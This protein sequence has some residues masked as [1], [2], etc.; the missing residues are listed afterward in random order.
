M[1]MK[2][3][4]EPALGIGERWREAIERQRSDDG[5][6]LTFERS[7]LTLRAA[8]LIM[9]WQPDEFSA[10]FPDERWDD[11]MDIMDAMR[12]RV[13]EGDVTA[14]CW[15]CDELLRMSSRSHNNMGL[16]PDKYAHAHAIVLWH[17]TPRMITMAAVWAVESD[18]A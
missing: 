18:D 3:E 14:W 1:K 9:G 2:S 8:K 6:K 15:F 7:E 4:N 16:P 5:S 10:W 17:L 13:L 11:A 12:Q